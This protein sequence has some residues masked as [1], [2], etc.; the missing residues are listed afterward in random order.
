M[1]AVI[2]IHSRRTFTI[3]EAEEILPI[4]RRITDQASLR[5]RDLQEQL[6]WVPR[7]EPLFRRL[8]AEL[9]LIVRR[10][11]VKIAQLGCEPR[12]VWLVDFDT[13]DG[14]LSWRQG[15]ESLS[16]FHPHGE[17]PADA[18]EGRGDKLLS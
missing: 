14:W 7:E 16:F 13:G 5:A 3:E 6:R 1:G 11:A 15:D 8:K 9:D 12:G 17:G 2:P 18:S 10:W 4:I